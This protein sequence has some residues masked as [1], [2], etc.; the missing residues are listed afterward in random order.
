[1]RVC[2]LL[3]S[4]W[5]HL[6]HQQF[7]LGSATYQ[8]PP[9]NQKGKW[10]QL[11]YTQEFSIDPTLT[12]GPPKCLDPKKKPIGPSSTQST[13]LLP[14]HMAFRHVATSNTIV[15]CNIPRGSQFLFASCRVHQRKVGVACG[16]IQ[17]TSLMLQ[18]EACFCNINN[19]V[20]HSEVLKNIQR[21]NI[22]GYVNMKLSMMLK[23]LIF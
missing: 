17:G 9:I 21:C 18:Y 12:L 16:Q 14:H 13:Q 4:P 2:R 19:E 22:V 15:G 3:A 5:P 6:T 10:T 7:A 1:M 8:A 23:C 20:V 11:H